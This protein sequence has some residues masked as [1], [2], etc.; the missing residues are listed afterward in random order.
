MDHRRGNVEE[1]QFRKAIGRHF[2]LKSEEKLPITSL[3]IP[4]SS[5]S[6]LRN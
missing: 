2:S 6:K 3:R 5:S 1:S 4:V